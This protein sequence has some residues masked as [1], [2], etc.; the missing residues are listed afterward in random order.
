VDKYIVTLTE[1]ERSSLRHLVSSGKAA[2]RKL[3]HARVLLLADAGPEGPAKADED[4]R[5]AL[6]VGP[7]TIHR[8]RRRFVLESFEAALSPRPSPLRPGKVKIQGEVEQALVELACSDPPRGRNRWTL[9]LLADR[10]VVLGKLPGV[11]LEAVRQAL[12]RT[13]SSPGCSRPG[14]SPPRR[15]RTSFTTWRTSCGPTS[16]PT[17][18]GPPW[19]AWTRR[20]SS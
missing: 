19:C 2:A 20:A 6:G 17:T 18:P 10:L 13:R 11:S 14:A 4:I 12:K 7:S 16:G 8:V 3:A 15:T 9:Q 1:E 5:Q